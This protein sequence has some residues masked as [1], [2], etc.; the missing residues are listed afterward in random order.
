MIYIVTLYPISLRKIVLKLII[1]IIQ[2]IMAVRIEPYTLLL[3]ALHQAADHPLLPML[4]EE[5]LLIAAAKHFEFSAFR[6]KNLKDV[7]FKKYAVC[8]APQ[9]HAPNIR[10]YL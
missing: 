4:F 1:S 7:L 10:L 2:R 8:S 3:N 6:W 5:T 9:K